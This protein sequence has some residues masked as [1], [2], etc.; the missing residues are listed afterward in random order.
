MIL[1]VEVACAF[2]T[3]KTDEDSKKTEDE[4]KKD[5]KNATEGEKEEKKK[6]EEKKE[7]KKPKKITVKEDIKMAVVVKDLS[8]PNEEKL[9]QAKKQ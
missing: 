5:D 3:E 4:T 2:Q 8:D 1:E 6:D 9:K 7:D